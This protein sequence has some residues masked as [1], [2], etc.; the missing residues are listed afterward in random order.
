[1]AAAH[2]R[3]AR[4]SVRWDVI[5]RSAARWTAEFVD[6]AGVTE[7]RGLAA[8]VGDMVLAGQCD[9]MLASMRATVATRPLRNQQMQLAAPVV[10]SW[11]YQ[12]GSYGVAVAGRIV[13]D[14]EGFFHWLADAGPAPGMIAERT[15]SLGGYQVANGVIELRGAAWSLPPQHW[16]PQPWQAQPANFSMQMVIQGW[17]AEQ[18]YLLTPVNGVQAQCQRL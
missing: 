15:V 16:M 14:G 9:R 5:R 1:M 4:P 3:A 10:G 17:N 2:S 12:G 18:L 8:S 7:A 6:Q 13:F 11:A